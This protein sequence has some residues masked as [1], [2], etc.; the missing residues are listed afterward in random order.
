MKKYLPALILSLLLLLPLINL[1]TPGLPITHDN[2]VH[3]ARIGN[4][5]IS[6]TEGNI[7]P[8]WAG[9]LNWGY[10]HPVM[11]FLYPLA[12]YLVSSV[13]AIGFSYVD[14]LKIVYAVSFVAS[15]LAMYAWARKEFGES[16]GF[17]TALLY[18]FAPY[19][20]VDLYVRGALGEHIAFI[21]PPLIM[22]ALFKLSQTPTKKIYH[23]V[24]WI[25]LLATLTSLL[26]LAHN[27]LSLMFLPF[28]L[29][30][31]VVLT[32]RLKQKN[33]FLLSSLFGIGYGFLLSAFFW[34]PAFLEGKYT[35]R[36][37]ITKG[38]TIT[39]F[40]TLTRIFYSPW[41]YAGTGEF[42]VQ[43]GVIGILLLI[44]SFIFIKRIR[45]KQ[46]LPLYIFA[47]IS[48][49]VSI[50]MMIRISEPLYVY[51]TILQKFQFPWRFLSL[52]VLSLSV[53]GGIV[54]YVF[55]ERT[56][57]IIVALIT[58]ATLLFTMSFWSAKDYQPYTDNYFE[59]IYAGTTDGGES[60][61]IWSIRFMEK[62]P[63]E[64]V[65]VISGNADI[66]SFSEN[67]TRKQFQ[68]S[69]LEDSRIKVNTLYFPDWSV[70][71]SGAEVPI[72]FQDQKQPGLI[73]FN[74]PA[75]HH[76]VLVL[77]QQTK[78]RKVASGVT[79]I[80]GTLLVIVVVTC[81][82]FILWRKKKS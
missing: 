77:F 39:R 80:A 36:D 76:D 41:K 37:I 54:I 66:K 42:S 15:G 63:K 65:E 49:I 34:I 45:K 30:Y 22:Y 52:S 50:I 19:R 31:V 58:A 73:T 14:S 7:V 1:L 59:K 35:L 9:N 5:Y 18:S 11:M 71:V 62:E 78:I 2:E 38:E 67:T 17:V 12:S 53:I 43:L 55:E 21:F 61:P 70:Y 33:I 60:S 27:M 6:L 57:K 44:V 16:G 82:A 3:L 79:I 51:L 8:K 72:E 13:H 4:F 24:L 81:T 75:G 32:L 56:Q 68:I 47:L 46:K 74:V 29:G 23:Q 28:I 48:L 69:A 25:C 40:E 26:I 64:K 20:F 10:G